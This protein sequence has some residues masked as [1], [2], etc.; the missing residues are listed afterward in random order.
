MPINHVLSATTPDDPAE[1]VRLRQRAAERKS[2]YKNI[3]ANRA[4]KREAA[5]RRNAK[6]PEKWRKY[7]R[8][9]HVRTADRNNALRRARRAKAAGREPGTP[10][11]KVIRTPE[12]K[13]QLSASQYSRWSK[14]NTHMT[15]AIVARRRARKL[16]ATPTWANNAAI[17]ALYAEAARL[18][19]E[20]GTP[21]E[22]D[23]YYPLTSNIV[24]GLHCEDNLR[25][26]T[27]EENMRK[28]NKCP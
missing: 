4:R 23:H 21:Y 13:K 11:P 6:D 20:T 14:A 17:K 5:K 24:C 9:H 25:V 19:S 26:I 2:Y 15:A 16:M 27:A 12:E 3:E 10:R 7:A 18:S 8:E 22:V 28:R 1:I